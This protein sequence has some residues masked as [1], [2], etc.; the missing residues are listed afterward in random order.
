MLERANRING[1]I[2]RLMELHSR[3][4][5][6]R[7]EIPQV[8]PPGLDIARTGME[9]ELGEINGDIRKGQEVHLLILLFLPASRECFLRRTDNG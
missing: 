2:D 3:V 6:Y 7:K 1:L 9:A 8:A 4:E 5:I